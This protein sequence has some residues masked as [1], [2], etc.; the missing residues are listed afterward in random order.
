VVVTASASTGDDIARITGIPRERI[1]VTP[2]GHRELP[3]PRAPSRPLPS[4]Y[5]LS[6]SVVEPRKAV[7]VLAE[8]VNMVP[9]CPPLMA[10]GGDGWS[11]S[12]IRRQVQEIDRKGLV[13]FLG[14]VEPEVL[15]GLYAGARLVI[16]STLAEGFGLPLLEALSAGAAVV[17]TD[18]PQA[19]EIAG[20]AALLIPPGDPEA[21]A[22]AIESLLADEG[23]QSDLRIRAL[24]RARSFTWERTT[25]LLVSA[26]QRAVG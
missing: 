6:V 20:D 7:E 25:N 15:S 1:V 18:I 12:A 13:R 17:A 4:E 3:P 8:A 22:G 5:L 26:Y 24:A 21:L 23:A 11:G 16:Q 10:V 9:G 2:L 19:R 14:Q